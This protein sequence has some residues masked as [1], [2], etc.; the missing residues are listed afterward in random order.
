[1]TELAVVAFT[2]FFITVG[3][4]DVAFVYAVLSA[5]ATTEQRRRMAIRGGLIATV[6]LLPFALWGERA[7]TWLGITLPAMQ[8]AG[9]ILLLLIGIDMV[10]ARGSGVSAP[11]P[12]EAREARGRADI[13]VF[14]LATP[15]LAGPGAMGAAIV[16]M[17]R[18]GDD[19]T[20]RAV[21]VGALL[22]VMA[23]ALV[24][25]LLATRIQRFLGATGA[26]VLQRV[27]GV[28]LCALAV[29]FF[30]DGLLASELFSGHEVPVIP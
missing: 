18:A 19:W 25:L 7:L 23:L 5:G 14:P 20:L 30:F 4:V 26:H 16:L 12:E 8:T 10:F 24:C 15:L 6:V 28:L 11:T 17:S 13:S 27:L 21:V 9:G 22:A 3:P 2:T 29:Q 1:M